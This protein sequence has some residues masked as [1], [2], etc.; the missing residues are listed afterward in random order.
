MPALYMLDTNILVH[1]VRGD[2]IGKSIQE[3]YSPAT[4]IPCPLISIVT[5]GEL[6]SLAYQFRWGKA[7]VDQALF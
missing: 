1:L 2:A 6:R 7:R 3:K 4:L 5:E